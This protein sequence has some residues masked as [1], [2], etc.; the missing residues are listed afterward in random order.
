MF[1][2]QYFFIT[3]KIA[4]QNENL[5]NFLYVCLFSSKL[6][7]KCIIFLLM[8]LKLVSEDCHSGG[9][10]IVLLRADDH[11]GPWTLA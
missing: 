2:Q 7:E 8:S 3:D 11:P 4:F 5:N 1:H 9:E 6:T 10:D